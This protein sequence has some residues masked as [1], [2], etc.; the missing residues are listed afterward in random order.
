[1]IRDILDTVEAKAT[2]GKKRKKRSLTENLQHA[3]SKLELIKSDSLGTQPHKILNR[4]YSATADLVRA[5]ADI[6]SALP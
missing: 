2:Y 3:E 4:L 5:I 1:M 6:E